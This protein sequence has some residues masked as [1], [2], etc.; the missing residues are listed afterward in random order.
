MLKSNVRALSIDLYKEPLYRNLD[1]T[2]CPLSLKNRYNYY[3]PGPNKKVYLHGDFKTCLCLFPCYNQLTTSFQRCNIVV[4]DVQTMLCRIP[5][6]PV[7]QD[8][9]SFAGECKPLFYLI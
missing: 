6:S 1:Q 3:A 2:R 7:F 4:V 5:F 8:N 9:L